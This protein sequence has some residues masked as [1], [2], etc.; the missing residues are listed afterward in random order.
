[1]QRLQSISFLQKYTSAM[2]Q[3]FELC[4]KRGLSP[5]D[6]FTLHNSL[7]CSYLHAGTRPNSKRQHP[8]RVVFLEKLSSLWAQEAWSSSALY[9]GKKPVGKDASGLCSRC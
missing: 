6:T 1:M 4:Q 7:S 8:D 3:Q 2:R 5:P 9:C